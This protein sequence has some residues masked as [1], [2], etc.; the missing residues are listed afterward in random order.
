MKFFYEDR[1]LL[2]RPKQAP[3]AKGQRGKRPDTLLLQRH[4]LFCSGW[5]KRDV[6]IYNEHAYQRRIS[7]RFKRRKTWRA[8]RWKLR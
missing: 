5:K 4:A 2:S 7:Y 8:A 3:Q 6:R 1:K